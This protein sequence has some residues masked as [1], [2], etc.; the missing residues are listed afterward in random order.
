MKN[1]ILALSL[2]IL[3]SCNNAGKPGD[4]SVSGSGK[5]IE[6]YTIKVINGDSIATMEGNIVKVVEQGRVKNG[7]REGFWVRYPDRDHSRIASLIYFQGGIFNGPYYL[8][9]GNGEMELAANYVNGKLD[10]D[11]TKYK[12]G[13]PV[14][15]AFY[16]DGNLHGKRTLYYTDKDLYTKIQKIENYNMGKYDGSVSWYNPEGEMTMEYIYK[17]GEQISGGIIER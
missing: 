3:V 16:I 1:I 12:F 15:L 4:G 6:G 17:N 11:Y 8:Y 5:T 10:G 14:E 13:Y 7:Q 2:F 9:S